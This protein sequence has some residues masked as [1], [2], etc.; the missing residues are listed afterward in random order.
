MNIP[1]IPREGNPPPYF[2]DN[3]QANASRVHYI[4][5]FAGSILNYIGVYYEGWVFCDL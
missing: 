2:D 5:R 1:V 3:V 4:N